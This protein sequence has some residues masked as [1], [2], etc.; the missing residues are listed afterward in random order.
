MKICLIGPGIMSIPP[1]GWGAVEILIW[2]Y[3]TELIN[4]GCE[5]DIVNI[6]RNHQEDQ[7]S[8]FTSYCQNLINQINS[9]EYDFVHLHYDR[10]YH[11]MP[12]L[13]CNKIGITSHYPYIDKIEKHREAGYDNIFNFLISQNKFYNFIL[14]DKDYN[15]F[16]QYGANSNLLKKIKNGINYHL[17]SYNENYEFDKTLYLGKITERKNQYKF[18]KLDNVD[19][20]GDCEDNKFNTSNSNYLGKWTRHQVHKN[21]T[22]YINLLLISKGEAD[23][24][25]VKE[26]L[27]C[28]L[29]IIINVSSAEN[30]DIT[31][32]FIT[33]IDDNKMDD[34]EYINKKIDEN[35]NI[36]ANLRN[37]IRDYGIKTFSIQLI[38]K[39]YID[40]IN[41][42]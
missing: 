19:Y 2:D 42:V 30:L 23:P 14:A 4:Q 20:V 34:L 29:G 13:K 33:I 15:T 37:E 35:K 1:P 38:I 18:Q 22:K 31:Q 10:L 24:L 11:I 25:V 28:G 5:V 36:C 16:L 3:Y 12:F 6:I 17:F 8:P 40:I 21:L 26:A 39:D 9:K 7:S 41:S 32:K 27:I